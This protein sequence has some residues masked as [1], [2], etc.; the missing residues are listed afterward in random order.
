[1][2]PEGLG[3]YSCVPRNAGLKSFEISPCCLKRDSGFLSSNEVGHSDIVLF[4]REVA[5]MCRSV[6]RVHEHFSSEFLVVAQRL[7]LKRCS[8][9]ISLSVKAFGE[10]AFL[11]SAG[12]VSKLSHAA[13]SLT[14]KKTGC[15]NAMSHLVSSRFMCHHPRHCRL[16]SYCHDFLSNGCANTLL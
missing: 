7:F 13:L 1:M 10:L 16:L 8:C 6:S 9:L 2:R 5:G 12:L 4:Q 3:G 14:S 15:A 11:A